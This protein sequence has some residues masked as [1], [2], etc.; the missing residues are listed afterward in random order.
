MQEITQ[1]A[2]E[3]RELRIELEEL[4]NQVVRGQYVPLFTKR[5][6]WALLLG[7]IVLAGSSV[8]MSYEAYSILVKTHEIHSLLID[9]YGTNTSLTD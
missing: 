6:M 8:F 2:Q 3:V 1:L 5:M 7:I 9:T 4:R